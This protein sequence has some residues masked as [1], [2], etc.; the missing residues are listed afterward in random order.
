MHID[1]M[2]SRQGLYD[3]SFEHDSCGIGLIADIRGRASHPIVSDALQIL[4]NLHHR[5]A[6]AADGRSGDGAGILT[7][8]P[9]LF[10]KK[11]TSGLGFVLP[12]EG[13]YAVGVT[14]L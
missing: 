3:P 10:L 6:A 5:G 1:A 4:C 12:E 7:R 13:D 2:P 11:A 8:I 14:F 9:H